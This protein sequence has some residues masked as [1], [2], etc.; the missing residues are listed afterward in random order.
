MRVR[1]WRHFVNPEINGVIH[2]VGE[3]TRIDVVVKVPPLSKIG[4]TLIS[5]FCLVVFVLLVHSAY[6]G[7]ALV[8]SPL[9]PTL[10]FLVVF[11]AYR[12]RIWQEADYSK[13]ELCKWFKG[14]VIKGNK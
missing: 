2:E 13:K 4:F 12:M 5:L 6:K 8:A 14:K 10:F 9:A 7:T 11:F 3:E 1:F